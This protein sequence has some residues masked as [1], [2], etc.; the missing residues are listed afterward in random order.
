MQQDLDKFNVEEI[1]LKD[2][3][4]VKDEAI[5]PPSG[6]YDVSSFGILSH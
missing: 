1:D 6:C 2:E 4:D 5:S 3:I